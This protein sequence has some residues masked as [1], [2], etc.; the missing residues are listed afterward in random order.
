MTTELKFHNPQT[1]VTAAKL[2]EKLEFARLYVA[3]TREGLEMAFPRRARV[4]L[5]TLIVWLCVFI[6]DA[7]GRSTTPTKIAS[8]SGLARASV[9]R[10]LETLIRFGK[11]VRIG[12]NYRLAT[13]AAVIDTEGKIL[14][15]LRNFT[16]K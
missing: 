2:R 12:S 16:R 15:I 8:H 3:L 6:G 5:E 4:D 14:K 9:Y 10:H 1:H 7:E 11:V 13:G